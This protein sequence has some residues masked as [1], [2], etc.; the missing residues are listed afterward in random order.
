MPEPSEAYHAGYEK[1]RHDNL[2]G[3]TGEV[4]FQMLRD[5][6]GGYYAAGYIDGAGGRPFKVRGSKATAKAAN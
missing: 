1:G 4:I 3:A 5:D 6:P 2:A